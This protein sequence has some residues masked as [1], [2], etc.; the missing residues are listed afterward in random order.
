MGKSSKGKKRKN[1]GGKKP[2]QPRNN[3]KPPVQPEE[4][5]RETG[6]KKKSYVPVITGLITVIAAIVIIVASGVFKTAEPVKT[7][8][9]NLMVITLDTL[10]ADRVG[11]YGY[12]DA[13]TP[14][15]DRLA[16][17]GVMF[18]NCYSPVP[19]TLPA[20][21][22]IFTGR[23]PLG[24][25]AR[26]NG[27]YVLPEK[28]IT[29][30]ELFKE[31]GYNTYG[32]IAAFV[33][34]S[35]FG[36]AQGFDVYDD[37]L[38]SHRMYNNY[39]SEIPATEVYRKF[40][41]WFEKNHH[42]KFFAWIHL[43]D[44]H[45]PY[46]PPKRFAKKFKR[47]FKGFYD[48]EVAFT[49]E[50]VGKIIDTLK[51]GNAL[52]NTV[53][54]IV[55]DHGEAF[56]EHEEYGHGIFCYDESLKVPMIFY[57]PKLF[58]KKGLRVKNRVNVTDIMPTLLE[59]FNIVI[60]EGVQ[61]RSFM[62]LL[63][64]EKEDKRRTFYFES[65]HG[66]DEMNWAPLMGIIHEQYKFISLPEPELY[67]LDA[68]PAEKENLFWKKNLL[69]KD[70][71]KKLMKQ[72]E[73]LS[74]TTS[75]GDARREITEEDKKH[76]TS[77]GY[78]SSFSG[79][80]GKE[81]DPKKGIVLDNNIKRIFRIIGK[82]DLDLAEKEL[83]TMIAEHPQI[84]MPVF[85]DLQHQLYNRQGNT[86]KATA[87]LEEA[88]EKYPKIERFYI[89]YGFKIFDLGMVKETEETCRKLLVLNPKFT[90]AYILLGQ[91]EEKRGRLDT[92]IG[93]YE[94]AL[95]IEP[96]N[97]SLKLKLAELMLQKKDLNAAMK[98]YD[99]LLLRREVSDNAGLLFKVG[100]LKSQQGRHADTE[101]L[102]KKAVAI[103]PSGKYYFNYA[104]VLARNNKFT[105]AM[106]NMQT[107]LDKYRSQLD[108]RQ[109]GI[110]QRAL[111]A[112]RQRTSQ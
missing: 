34:L 14:N 29:L 9:F 109:I 37:S 45:A 48:A 42:K 99:E 36:L 25:G 111:V 54:V 77:L 63:M 23:S 60:P 3:A 87:V 96:Q 51:H 82:G 43:Y 31:K 32:V 73:T 41:Q 90:R 55:G 103:A 102:L 40:L 88:M 11:V 85:Y 79:K 91:V 39:N 61:A 67:D 17:E 35:K 46:K 50:A 86:A 1:T 69:A 92:A 15:L 5:K 22:S 10:R 26:G 78:I 8:N 4:S 74:K 28:E 66:K 18:E 105:G 59:L 27:I 49:D 83:N 62:P 100:L 57:N 107:A 7:D 2:P 33:L 47:D 75:A 76:L 16:N 71:D 19:L 108:E 84:D 56:G 58:P 38:D 110:A 101:Q 106:E 104:M 80:G 97:I 68:D 13:L 72:V 6:A 53:V 65:M 44:P 20:H 64:A 89:L 93:H 95:D 98:F 12:K 52:E 21:S 112:W 24:H 70:L 81:K 30:A 94:K